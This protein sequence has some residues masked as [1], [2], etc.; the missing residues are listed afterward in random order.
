MADAANAIGRTACVL[1]GFLR[2]CQT[3]E[4]VAFLGYGIV[5][6]ILIAFATVRFLKSL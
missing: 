5:V 1:V 3:G 2:Q 4:S 6:L